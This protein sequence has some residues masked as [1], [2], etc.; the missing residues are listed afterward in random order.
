MT[1]QNYAI[2]SEKSNIFQQMRD[3]N[4][5]RATRLTNSEI[6]KITKLRSDKTHVDEALLVMRAALVFVT[7]FTSYCGFLFY[8]S[9]FSKVFSPTETWAAAVGLAIMTEAAKIFLLHRFLRSIFFGW[10]SAD[11]WSL[12]GW[13]FIGALAV[14]AY[15][16]SVQ[17]STDGMEM[18]TKQVAESSTPKNNL[19]ALIRENTADID[20]QIAASQASQSAAINTKWKGTTT[21]RAQKSAASSSAAI[22][23]L[24]DQRAIIVEQV[25]Q[26]YQTGNQHRAE[27]IT[28][29]AYWIERY[30]GYMELVAA[31]CIFAVVFFERRLVAHNIKRAQSSDSEPTPSPTPDITGRRAAHTTHSSAGHSAP[32]SES[33]LFQNLTASPVRDSATLSGTNTAPSAGTDGD[34]IRLRL[35][36]LKGWDDNFGKP[37]NRPDT[38]AHNMCKI[39]NEIGQQMTRPDF[40]PDD[41]SVYD[42]LT[43]ITETGFPTMDKHGYTY[44]HEA[45]LIRICRDYLPAKAA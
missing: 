18:L 37:G 9:T 14:G 28:Q 42:L 8:Q 33:A 44:K 17:I 22:A 30:G 4:A 23:S 7:I 26:D 10:I 27:N 34:F 41:N 43:Y 3:W 19:S 40:R 12:G 5:N 32:L 20:A 25:T 45:D 36:S 29:W 24:Q 21:W 11:W 31:L 35:K 2:S 38:V 15:I 16:W 13:L 39:L 6:N 1:M